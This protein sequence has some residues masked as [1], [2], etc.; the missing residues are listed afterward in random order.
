MILK[1]MSDDQY[2]AYMNSKGYTPLNVPLANPPG[3]SIGS[4]G[5]TVSKD[6]TFPK[7]KHYCTQDCAKGAMPA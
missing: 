4:D 6:A 5:Y 7:H 3:V 2:H 1:S